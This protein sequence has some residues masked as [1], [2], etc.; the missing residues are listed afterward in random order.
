MVRRTRMPGV[1]VE[2]LACSR[3]SP[4]S[5][6]I[7]FDKPIHQF[8]GSILVILGPAACWLFAVSVIVSSNATQATAFAICRD[9]MIRDFRI[10]CGA[11][12]M[13][14]RPK[15]NV[16]LL[17]AFSVIRKKQIVIPTVYP[18]ASAGRSEGPCVHFKPSGSN[19]FA[20]F[21]SLWR[22]RAMR[23]FAKSRFTARLA[24]PPPSRRFAPGAPRDD[25]FF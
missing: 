7:G 1:A 18:R 17:F 16:T 15:P 2:T 10:C 12:L 14:A 13:R 19:V 24:V 22:K 20:N 5:R 25:D 6:S 9:A 4:V 23:Q 21:S 11:C 3:F 8:G